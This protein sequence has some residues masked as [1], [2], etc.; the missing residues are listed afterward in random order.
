MTASRMMA[1]E[2]RTGRVGVALLLACSLLARPSLGA[3]TA[4]EKETA[5]SLMKSARAK[6][7]SGDLHGALKD[8]TAARAIMPV[9]T[10]G[11]EM[12]KTQLEL[13]L[14]VEARD[15][16][17]EVARSPEERGEPKPITEARTAASE[18]AKEILPR[19]PS[20]RI[21]LHGPR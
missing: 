2:R 21:E 19:I 8:F 13:G 10:T 7:K 1:S 18:L 3:P 20:A 14:L 6:R 5:R 9:T 16:L 17:L 15:T 12:G 4:A 11:L